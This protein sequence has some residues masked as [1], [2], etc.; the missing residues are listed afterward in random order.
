MRVELTRRFRFESAHRLPM[1]PPEHKCHRVHGHSFRI[2]VTLEGEIDPQMGWLVDFG[3]ISAR[4]EPVLRQELDHRLLNDV[5]GLEN[6]TSEVLSVW[7]W[8][9]RRDRW[10][11]WRDR[12]L[13]LTA[14]GLATYVLLPTAPP[15]LAAREGELDPV[16]RTAGRGWSVIGL[17]VAD[18]VL[19]LG[20]AAVNLTAAL[21]S[22]HAAYAAFTAV[23]LWRGTRRPWRALLAAYP[24]AMGFA[25]VVSGEH[26]VFDVLLGYLYAAGTVVLVRRVERWWAARR[27]GT[28]AP[29]L[30]LR[31]PVPVSA[32]GGSPLDGSPLDRSPAGPSPG[33]PAEHPAVDH[34]VGARDPRRQV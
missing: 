17:E 15:W 20:R 26:Y 8:T 6:P 10:V 1:V 14:L 27:A 3:E 2:D 9:R 24:L 22:L 31:E 13:T 7:L 33:G 4:V 5:P 32:G 18:R 29:V 30:D 25:L 23:A 34:Q 12:F 11:W 19:D 16:A 21:P 28:G